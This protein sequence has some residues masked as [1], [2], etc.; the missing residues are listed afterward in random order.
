M[1]HKHT[2]THAHT[3]PHPDP[4]DKGPGALEGLDPAGRSLSEA[5]RIS[6]VI[7]KV[8]MVVLVIAFLVSGFKT[9]GP[10]EKALVLRF[11]A[12]RGVGDE[13]VLE[14][15]AHWV[16]PYPIDEMV[17]IP[18][19][20]QISLPIDTFWYRLT[21]DDIIGSG[22]RPPRPIP[23][24]LN[25]LTDG[26][27]LTRSEPATGED[28][29]RA[30]A[31]AL[32]EAAIVGAE[33]SDYNIVHTMWQ[34]NY[35]IDNVE[36]FF[37]NVYVRETAPGQVY[38]DVLKTSVAPLLKSVV[39]NA[40]VTSLVNYTIDEALQSTDTI[41]RDVAQMAQRH[42]DAIDSGIR[43]SSVQ[44]VDVEWPKQVND[45][46]EAFIT[47]TQTS[48]QTV[49][50]ARSYAEKTLQDTAG[51]VA[52]LLY[53]AVMKDP[54]DEQELEVLWSQVEGRAR[55]R[56]SRAQADRTVV[57]DTAKANA[58]YFESILPE[59][60]KRPELVVQR[61]YLDAIEQVLANADEKFVMQPS[62]ALKGQEVR[63][64]L[65]KDPLLKPK[66][67]PA[68]ATEQTQ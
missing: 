22:P 46:F 43:L 33:G 62:E 55:E 14:P 1:A 53:E 42:L 48:Q 58:S 29:E 10:G 41:R 18:V 60:R 65:N 67:A 66:K 13:R 11:G 9:V 61:L 7:L 26:Y 44:L 8:I 63:I 38:I 34:V 27:C 40:V 35:Q 19:K 36:K 57:I 47:A 20:E 23:E 17:K 50:E 2:H 15:G 31:S 39:D 3:H 59:Y 32:G 6:F 21:R 52:D 49:S 64:L 4:S 45:A 51:R 30:Y 68:A 56:I 12:I 16:F 28:V 37:E 54:P 5:L 25:P 24:K